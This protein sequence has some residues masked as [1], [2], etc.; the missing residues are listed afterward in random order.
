MTL[1]I[2]VSYLT[3]SAQS[4]PLPSADSLRY[5][6]AQFIDEGTMQAVK[7]AKEKDEL[8]DKSGFVLGV[9]LGLKKFDAQQIISGFQELSSKTPSLNGGIILGYQY[10][11]NKY[12]GLRLTGMA[13]VGTQARIKATKILSAEQAQANPIWDLYQSYL[14]VQAGADLVFLATVYEGEKSSF[15]LS[16]GVGYEADWYVVQKASSQSTLGALTN[17]LQSPNSLV[18]QGVYPEFGIF[19][20]YGSHQFEIAYRF[21]EFS[22]MGDQGREWDFDLGG[23]QVAKTKT[24][25]LK[26]SSLVLSYLYRF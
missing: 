11:F 5:K 8:G 18:N 17:L 20:F 9:S 23:G 14:P 12:V 10:F 16:A 2:L 1:A 7:K 21:A 13:N 22:L 26:T 15:G 19:Y 24:T 25:F 4:I 6:A 3:L